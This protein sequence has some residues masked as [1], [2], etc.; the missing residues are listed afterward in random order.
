MLT[1]NTLDEIRRAYKR[2]KALDAEYQK[3]FRRNADAQ[4]LGMR[5]LRAPAFLNFTKG[6]ITTLVEATVKSKLNPRPNDCESRM[7]QYAQLMRMNEDGDCEYSPYMP[8]GALCVYV[9]DGIEIGLPD[10]LTRG[11]TV[12]S[13]LSKPDAPEGMV[14][15]ILFVDDEQL[16]LIRRY[17]DTNRTRALSLRVELVLGKKGKLSGYE[18]ELVC[19]GLKSALAA[20]KADYA[21]R[22]KFSPV[23]VEEA[24]LRYKDVFNAVLETSYFGKDS[25]KIQQAKT[26]RTASALA[27]IAHVWKANPAAGAKLISGIDTACAGKCNNELVGR[28][29]AWVGGRQVACTGDKELMFQAISYIGKL[30]I[31]DLKLSAEEAVC[32]RRN[33]LLDLR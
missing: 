10:G 33:Y 16:E 26:L 11:K 25:T 27:G 8:N 32:N 15:P 14:L 22:L 3:V 6:G 23:Q 4:D 21:S 1:I 28:L 30:L 24:A 13:V 20:E 5:P 31:L 19:R 17:M 29:W 12:A 7:E 18:K 9:G 2:A